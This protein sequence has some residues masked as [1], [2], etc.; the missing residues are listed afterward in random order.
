V[1]HSLL[2]AEASEDGNDTEETEAHG[3]VDA[4]FP[5]R[6]LRRWIAGMFGAEQAVEPESP[7]EQPGGGARG[8]REVPPTS[9]AEP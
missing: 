8:N 4:S 5:V 9:E 2:W 3:A 6:R 1:S 7:Q